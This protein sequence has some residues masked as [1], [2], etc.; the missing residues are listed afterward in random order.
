MFEKR[1]DFTLVT[2]GRKLFAVGGLHLINNEANYLNTVESYD[3]LENR[4]ELKAPMN[5]RRCSHGSFVYEDRLYVIGGM[6]GPLQSS[7]EYYDSTTNKWTL[8]ISFCNI[9]FIEIFH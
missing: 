5:H 4:W 7:V 6:C 3:P 8:V 9:F 2:M 1:R